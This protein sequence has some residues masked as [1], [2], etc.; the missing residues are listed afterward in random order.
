VFNS[1]VQRGIIIDAY[2]TRKEDDSGSET[3]AVSD[4]DPDEDEIFF[5][6]MSR[7]FD[8]TSHNKDSGEVTDEEPLSAA[9][10]LVDSGCHKAIDVV[11]I[12]AL[13]PIQLFPKVEDAE[14]GIKV[15]FV[16]PKSHGALREEDILPAKEKPPPPAKLRR[17]VSSHDLTAIIKK[18]EAE[19]NLGKM[20]G[21][22]S[23]GEHSPG[24]NPPEGWLLLDGTNGGS[25]KEL[26]LPTVTSRRRLC[27][28]RTKEAKGKARFSLRD[29]DE[30]ESGP[31]NK[32]WEELGANEDQ[33]GAGDSPPGRVT[34]PQIQ[35]GILVRTLLCI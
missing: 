14:R 34:E 16:P 23:H 32:G 20:G 1:Y 22:K 9:P 13:P 17:T 18:E 8:F 27:D 26:F 2:V 15:I 35:A 29:E 25:D 11:L 30:E 4:L 31:L 6:R 19:M 10:T 21:T 7:A 5:K 3:D 12:Q 28:R 33:C 24:G